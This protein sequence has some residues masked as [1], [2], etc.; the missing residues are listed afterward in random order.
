M[1]WDKE[2][3]IPD[4]GKIKNTDNPIYRDYHCQWGDNLSITKNNKFRITPNNNYW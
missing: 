1:F 4:W 2:A 3:R